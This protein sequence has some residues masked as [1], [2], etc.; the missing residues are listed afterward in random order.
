MLI[1]IL[2]EPTL[3]TLGSGMLE[4]FSHAMSLHINILWPNYGLIDT[5]LDEIKFSINNTNR[6]PLILIWIL[7]DDILDSKFDYSNISKLNGYLY[8]KR[9]AYHTWDYS[10]I[11]CQ[12]VMIYGSCII[13]VECI[14]R[15]NHSRTCQIYY[16]LYKL[17]SKF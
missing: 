9:L 1:L 5:D 16:L 15:H 2:R 6:N 3:I 12:C 8:L 13:C 10:H 7:F 11:F 14:N 4:W 17:S